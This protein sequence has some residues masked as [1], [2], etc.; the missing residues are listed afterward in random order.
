MRHAGCA[1]F[2]D[3]SARTESFQSK[4]SIQGMGFIMSDGVGKDMARARRGFK[5][6][7]AP[8]TVKIQAL[9]GG[10]ADDR[11]GIGRGVDNTA[12]LPIHAHT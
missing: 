12:P 9:N 5:A 1:V 7:R 8:A 2:V 4:S 10:F 3:E 11:A 6:T